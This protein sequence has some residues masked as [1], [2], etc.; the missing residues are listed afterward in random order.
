MHAIHSGAAKWL[1]EALSPLS[2]R[3]QH[4]ESEEPDVPR[5]RL[6]RPLFIEP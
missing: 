2:A 3:A 4:P 5:D 1:S 6:L